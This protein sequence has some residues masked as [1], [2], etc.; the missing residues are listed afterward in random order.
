MLMLDVM[1]G[2][3]VILYDRPTGKELGFI[4]FVKRHAPGSDKRTLGFQ[5]DNR[6]RIVRGSIAGGTH[7]GNEADTR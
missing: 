1:P 3:K 2:D 7:D 6:I 4:K 5:L